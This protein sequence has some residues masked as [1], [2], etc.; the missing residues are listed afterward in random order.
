MHILHLVTRLLQ[1]GSEENTVATC[2]WQA[3]AGHRVTLAHG[4]DVAPFWQQSAIPGV[5]LVAVPELIHPLRPLSDCRALISLRRLFRATLPDVIHTHQSKAGVLG[6]LAADAVPGA[7]VVHGIHIVP[8]DGVGA[9]RRRLYLGAER[10]AAARTDVFI[11]VSE[12][13]SDA[14]VLAGLARRDQVHCV[15]SGMDLARF[16]D[17]A[18]PG[19]WRRLLNLAPEDERPFVALMLA[20]FEPRKRHAELLAAI[21]RRRDRL[22]GFKLLL[23]GTGPQSGAIRQAVLDHGLQDI[24]GFCGHR[25]D[26]EAL[27]ALADLSILTSRRE[28]L[29]RVVVQS[30][31]AGCPVLANDLPGLGEILAPGINGEI[32]GRDD[33]DGL[34]LR[35]AALL[36]DRAMLSR[37]RAGARASD[38]GAWDLEALGA[39]TTALYRRSPPERQPR[40]AAA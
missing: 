40:P 34:V 9:L 37:L 39:A 6:R 12:A 36:N 4:R 20:A 35:M 21:A 2:R 24:V 23:A 26:P 10:L 30:V 29:P 27:L 19:D 18:L 14:Y 31:A 28:G 7:T 5:E 16:R 8:F 32:L 22:A 13:V 1:A 17:P 15:R 38:V 25:P 3:A 11:G 33:I